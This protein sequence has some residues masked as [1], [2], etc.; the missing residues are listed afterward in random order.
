MRKLFLLLPF[1]FLFQFIYAT[2]DSL[3]YLL[4]KDTIFI[5]MGNYGEK[6]FEHKM[7]K[8]QTLYSLARFYGLKIPDL[9]FY[10][11]ELKNQSYKIG[12]IVRIP[13]PN[14]AIL[15]YLNSYYL[16]EDFVPVCYV[17]QKGDTFYGIS[18]RHFDMPLDTI[19]MRNHLML[20]EGLKPGQTL[21]IGWMS[22][23]GIPDSL[24]QFS[25]NPLWKKSYTLRQQYIQR[26]YVKKEF[27]RNGA[28]FW[29]KEK[30]GGTDLYALHRKAP[31][32]SIIS[33][34][35]PMYSRTIFVK[36]IGKISNK[37]YTDDVEVVLSPAVAQMLGAIDPKFFVEVRY[38]R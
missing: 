19:L 28:A 6:I 2:G 5:S 10:N 26:S 23:Y 35:N 4:P 14:R 16:E 17:V 20:A 9:Y 25:G 21:R 36:V 3:N 37:V 22:M 27:A 1:C 13:I 18:K 24:R 34:T 15:R 38:L 8:G 7:E 33:V 31:V 12:S 32:N 29:N 11:P 30:K